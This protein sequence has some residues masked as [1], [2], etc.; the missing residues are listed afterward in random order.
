MPRP[1]PQRMDSPSARSSSASPAACPRTSPAAAALQHNASSGSAWAAPASPQ[2]Q[3]A[4]RS[5][6]QASP[7]GAVVEVARPLPALSLRPTDLGGGSDARSSFG[8][9]LQ[10]STEQAQASV[11]AQ[12]QHSGLTQQPRQTGAEQLTQGPRLSLS[13]AT[14]AADGPGQH[15]DGEARRASPPLP[16]PAVRSTPSPPA[17]EQQQEEKPPARPRAFAGRPAAGE[18]SQHRQTPPLN[19]PAAAEEDYTGDGYAEL[20]HSRPAARRM[21]NLNDSHPLLVAA[22]AA[23]GDA[24]AAEHVKVHHGSSTHPQL[25]PICCKQFTSQP[26]CSRWAVQLCYGQSPVMALRTPHPKLGT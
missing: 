6:M 13:L 22:A 11:A 1:S 9:K 18:A 21:M 8:W 4:K 2:Q 26:P 16:L 23:Q 15:R 14:P 25:I 7:A 20:Q 5:L 3:A 19:A 12:S 17:L 24:A 10:P